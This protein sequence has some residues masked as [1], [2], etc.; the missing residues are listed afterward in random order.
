MS[1]IPL[2]ICKI[3]LT[4]SNS[5]Q[6]RYDISFRLFD[7]IQSLY[8]SDAEYITDENILKWYDRKE[9]FYESGRGTLGVQERNLD[10]KSLNKEF[11]KRRLL[12]Q[13]GNKRINYLKLLDK[14][15]K[16]GTQNPFVEFAYSTNG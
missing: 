10:Y 11:A 8:I 16:R 13:T 1:R 7:R 4:I 5:G 6:S 9:L 3:S 14:L 12:E 2:N 15:Y